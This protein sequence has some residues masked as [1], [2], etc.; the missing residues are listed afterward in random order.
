MLSLRISKYLM[1]K[2]LLIGLPVERRNNIEFKYHHFAISNESTDQVSDHQWWLTSQRTTRL[3]V[4]PN[5]RMHTTTHE[6]VLEN[7]S[8]VNLVNH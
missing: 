1:N 7:K 6:V 4:P 2:F 3:S 5:R 8:S